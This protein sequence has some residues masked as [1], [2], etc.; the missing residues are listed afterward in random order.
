MLSAAVLV[1]DTGV[2][3]VKLGLDREPV[4]SFALSARDVELVHR[5]VALTARILFAAGAREVLLPF[6]HLPA[7]ASVDDVAKI[8][9]LPRRPEAIELLTVHIMGSARMAREPG[10]GVCDAFGFVHGAPG[11]AVADASL[12]PSSVG[13]NPQESIMAL[14]LRNAEQWS[15]SL[16]RA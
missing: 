2:G 7:L 9:S 6:A 3:R 14:A 4:M 13:V 16:V 1:E 15:R 12:F 11:L 5:G 8:E 10:D